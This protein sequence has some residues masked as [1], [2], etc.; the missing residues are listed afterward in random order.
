MVGESTTKL[1]A[2]TGLR[3]IG[4]RE[5]DRKKREEREI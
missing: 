5:I 2:R 4:K 1:L 3:N